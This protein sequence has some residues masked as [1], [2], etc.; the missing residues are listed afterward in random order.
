MYTASIKHPANYSEST[1]QVILSL[2]TLLLKIIN[3]RW[4][5]DKLT[6]KNFPKTISMWLAVNLYKL[7]P[8]LFLLIQPE[9]LNPLK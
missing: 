1:A 6:L 5:M 7:K 4:K 3:Y 8:K 2:L 9:I